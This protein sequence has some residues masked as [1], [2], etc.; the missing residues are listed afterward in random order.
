MHI[1]EWITYKRTIM[2]INPL[3]AAMGAV[4]LFKEITSHHPK[5]KKEDKTATLTSN[6]NVNNM[7]LDDLKNMTALLVRQ[8]KLSENDANNFLTQTASLV[9]SA[10]ISKD[11]KIDMVKLYEQQVQNFNS[12]SKPKDLAS[13]QQSLDILNGMKALSGANIPASV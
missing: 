4:Q 9:Q 5:D 12:E 1:V 7:S 2:L 10:G 3:T 13:F 8:G 6:Y 11:K